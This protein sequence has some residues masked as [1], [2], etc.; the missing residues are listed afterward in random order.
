MKKS[1]KIVK[2]LFLQKYYKISNEKTEKII[3]IEKHFINFFYSLPIFSSINTPYMF[4]SLL[5]TVL[6][7]KLKKKFV[8]LILN[9]AALFFKRKN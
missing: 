4:A 7:I 9:L 6:P 8:H 1:K 3:Q 2:N 5:L